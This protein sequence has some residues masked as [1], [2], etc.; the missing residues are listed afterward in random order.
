MRDHGINNYTV[1][2]A[3][4]TKEF[5]IA[6]W[7]EFIS[8]KEEEESSSHS[9]FVQPKGEKETF[10]ENASISELPKYN[11]YACIILRNCDIPVVSKHATKT[12][13]NYLQEQRVLPFMSAAEMAKENITMVRRQ[14]TTFW[15]QEDRKLLNGKDDSY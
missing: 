7:T 11:Y 14:N 13:H 2:I 1:T 6:S 12:N 15:I 8:W 9:Y 3:M 4:V 5:P 10:N